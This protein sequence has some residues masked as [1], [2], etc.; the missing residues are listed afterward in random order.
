MNEK[1]LNAM[2]QLFA[3]VANIGGK[4][5]QGKQ[6][7]ELF[8]RQQVT[9]DA[10]QSYLDL[11]DSFAE[12]HAAFFSE[13]S[14]EKKKM[15][16]RDSVK[17]LVICEQ[18]N[19]E[20]TQ[21]QKFVLLVRLLE[22]I[23]I[24]QISDVEL[25]FVSTV[26]TAFNIKEEEFDSIQNYIV[27]KDIYTLAEKSSDILVAD[28]RSNLEDTAIRYLHVEHLEGAFCFLRVQS[29]D[30]YLTKYFGRED[31]YLNGMII[32]PEQTYLFA[33]GSSIRS[34]KTHPIYFSDIVSHYMADTTRAKILFQAE[35][36][37]HRFATGTGGLHDIN[38]SE[39][40][41]K[42]IGLMG[43][44]GAGKTTLL[45]VLSGIM[46][47][48]SAKITINGYDIF[49]EPDMIEGVIGY[50]S[51]D[52]LL[53]EELTVYQNLYYNAKL[54]LGKLTEEELN[55]VVTKTLSALGLLEIKNL[56]VGSPINK[57]I[58][59]GQRK[60]L[61]IGLEL[62]R[63]PSVLFVDEPTSGL[64]SRDSDN[65]MDLLKELALKGKLIFVVI[66]QPSS[67][68]FKM[69]DKLLILDVGGYPVYY[70]NPVESI[71]YFR[72]L[73]NHVNADKSECVECGNVNPEQVF[74]IIE[75]KLVD[76]YGSFTED[77]KINPIGMN[78]FF[79]ERHK[80]PEFKQIREE[81]TS[82]LHI[83]SKLKQ[84]LIFTIRDVL[85]KMSNVQYI[86]INLLEAPLLAFVLAFLVRYFNTDESGNSSYFFGD[87]ENIPAYLFM[88]VIVALFIGM[89]VSAEE[90]IKDRLILKREQFLN[91]SKGSY[92]LSKVFILFS[93]SAIQMFTFAVIGNLILDI[94]GMTISYWLV[95]FTTA[96]FANMLGLNISATFNSAV[97]IYILIPVLLI[98][99]LLLSGVIVKFDKLNPYLSTQEH[100]PIAGDI[101]TSKWAFEALAVNQFK[102]N[103]YEKLFYKYDKRL[104]QAEYIKLF[105]QPKLLSKIG[106]LENNY[107]SHNDSIVQLVSSSLNLV[108]SELEKLSL[109]VKGNKR[110]KFDQIDKL[111]LADFDTKVAA[112][113]KEYLE[114][115]KKQN[116]KIWNA[117]YDKRDKFMSSLRD[118]EEKQ[119]AFDKLQKDH[120]NSKL[121]MMVEN[122]RD[123]N[124]I[125]ERDGKLIQKID[126][127][128]LDPNNKG[129]LLDFRAHFYAPRKHFMG[130][131]YN[132][133]S[134]NLSIIWSMTVLL[135]ITLY[136]DI[137]K[138]ILN[139]LNSLTR[140]KLRLLK[141]PA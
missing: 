65:I 16:V 71:I 6:I 98:P 114:K 39:E 88:A 34:T 134:F 132:T 55:D 133:F 43:A 135:Y 60:R 120:Y 50:I 112:D 116:I 75:A 12:K 119:E 106:F 11:F 72:T 94:Q 28:G 18:I 128:Y 49:D 121:T 139:S 105:L 7:V 15:P 89:T 62:I 44:S 57:K 54:C 80:V 97:T 68:I 86:M 101:M 48:T 118:T 117:V 5:Q 59:G 130:R 108:R 46:R 33:N 113:A 73:S 127:I 13:S 21:K 10:V 66:H 138:R 81:I 124:M 100:V 126:P 141:K 56:R 110:E 36:V 109:I 102:N 2:M 78:E 95:L 8:I 67:D 22:F 24:D 53:M 107:R 35:H 4:T 23:N 47:P 140:L 25:D 40:S 38:I 32:N 17:A 85:S 42:L 136:Y 122:Q 63:E 93:V 83:A 27:D 37:E 79:L 70:G 45:N 20:L 1:L 19:E 52:D 69:F 84:F 129:N 77:R 131:L 87:N 104:S 111:N 61:N 74:N 14:K 30:M 91:L 58:S 125:I 41:G 123:E 29:V 90:I 76:E 51:Q 115:I 96:C 99:Q 64:S 31:L 3:I 92:L 9:L 103:E 82:Q 137:F 26:A